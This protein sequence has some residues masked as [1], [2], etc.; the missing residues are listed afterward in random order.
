M[1]RF[2][3]KFENLYFYFSD[4]AEADERNAAKYIEFARA[5]GA[6]HMNMQAMM[7]KDTPFMRPTDR[8][9]VL[10]YARRANRIGKNVR[11]RRH[12]G[13]H[14]SP[15]QHA[16]VYPRANRFIYAKHGPRPAYTCAWIPRTSLW[17]GWTWC[18]LPA[19]MASASVMCI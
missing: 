15:C 6:G 9:A 14:A 3:V 16:C 18:R 10:D 5:V 2:N 4:D 12:Q 8:E 7:W 13:M 11:G 19:Y 1:K 17:P